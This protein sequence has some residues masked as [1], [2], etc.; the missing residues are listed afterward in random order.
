MAG[1]RILDD[2][3]FAGLS[4]RDQRRY[5]IMLILAA[6]GCVVGAEGAAAETADALSISEREWA[7]SRRR[8]ETA[9][10]PLP[11][12]TL[13]FHYLAPSLLGEGP[14][15]STPSRERSTIPIPAPVPAPMEPEFVEAELVDPDRPP[16]ED[17]L[18]AWDRQMPEHIARPKATP[19]LKKAIRAR[20]GEDPERRSLKWWTDLFETVVQSDFLLGLT[21]GNLWQ[22]NLR[23]LLKP[24]NLEKVVEGNYRACRHA[25]SKTAANNLAVLGEWNAD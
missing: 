24:A 2:P 20:W 15:I 13:E 9:G 4:E 17:I 7:E 5:L 22:V 3:R 16:L 6:G 1:V 8:F 14:P 18:A 21:P 11:N 10:L 23:W 12:G 25:G 19:S